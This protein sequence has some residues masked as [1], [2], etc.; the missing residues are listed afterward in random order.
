VLVSLLK[1]S[2]YQTLHITT[3]TLPQHTSC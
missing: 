3:S 1:T 2:V